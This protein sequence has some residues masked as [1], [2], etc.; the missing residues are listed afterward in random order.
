VTDIYSYID[1]QNEDLLIN[2]VPQ[3]ERRAALE[4]IVREK[5]SEVFTE[6][7]F[8]WEQNTR[9]YTEVSTKTQKI[10]EF[11]LQ[12]VKKEFSL[13]EEKVRAMKYTLGYLVDSLVKQI[14]VG[15]GIE[16]NYEKDV[17][18]DKK[19]DELT[20]VLIKKIREDYTVAISYTEFSY[21]YYCLYASIIKDD[22][23][24]SGIVIA[25]HG[26]VASKMAAVSN[27]F[28]KNQNI[29]AV[30]MDL[31]MN[32][33]DIYSVLKEAIEEA[34]QGKGVLFLTDMGSLTAF[35]TAIAKE[36]GIQVETI[37]RTD[38]LMVLEA[39]NLTATSGFSISE[40]KARLV[41]NKENK[42]AEVNHNKIKIYLYCQDSINYQFN[43]VLNFLSDNFIGF[44]EKYQIQL[45]SSNSEINGKTESI[46]FTDRDFND[47]QNNILSISALEEH[48]TLKKIR[49]TL[50]LPL[51]TNMQR[52]LSEELLFLNVKIKKKEQIIKFLFHELL[53]TGCVTNK[54]Y[55]NLIEREK[56]VNTYVGTSL[57]FPHTIDLS[58]IEKSQIAIATFEDHIDWDGFKVDIV[59]M[60]AI[61]ENAD[62]YF[63]QVYK[64]LSSKKELI[65]SLKNPES[66]KNILI[67]KM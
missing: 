12:R 49:T 62:T 33:N 23:Q 47:E 64:L 24:K 53:E 38:T 59:C 44:K 7:R 13:P 27:F 51:K 28:L 3:V 11:F 61:K 20:N 39:S 21:I 10:I 5:M 29:R 22:Y 1:K 67:T 43:Y 16:E 48:T 31:E 60:L 66:F 36:T 55:D 19:I 32:P 6:R 2:G 37:E 46:I 52:V 25:M 57:A 14:T 58:N 4:K 35:G 9:Y 8:E 15:V 45:I 65:K 63:E 17:Y 34:D 41:E 42:I 18:H 54:F 56:L 40:V 26:E 50:R 30:D